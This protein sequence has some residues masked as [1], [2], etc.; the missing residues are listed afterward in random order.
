MYASRGT[1]QYGAV[2]PIT[3]IMNAAREHA[4]FV[5]D[6]RVYFYGEAVVRRPETLTFAVIKE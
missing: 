4:H 1:V 5:S 6:S 3:M 2:L